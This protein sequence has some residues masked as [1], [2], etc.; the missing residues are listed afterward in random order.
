MLAEGFAFGGRWLAAG[1][2]SLDWDD[3]AGAA[4]YELMARAADGWVLLDP[5]EPVGGLLVEFNG[6][7]VRPRGWVSPP[8]GAA[9]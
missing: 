4:D 8:R 1:V 6:P 3:V 9:M 7:R 5:R 2:V